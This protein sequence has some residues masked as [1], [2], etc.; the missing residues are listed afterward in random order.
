[1]SWLVLEKVPGAGVGLP[2]TGPS[3]SS[4]GDDTHPVQTQIGKV[5]QLYV[6]FVEVIQ[7]YVEFVE[8][9][10]L[11]VEFVEVIQLY[12]EF[13]EVIQLHVEFDEVIQLHVGFVE[14]IQLHV[15]FVEVIQL[16]VEFVEV[17]QLYVGFVE[18][19]QLHVEF[20]EVIQLHVGYVEVIQLHVEFVEVIQLHVGFVEVIQLYVRFVEVIQLYVEF[21]EVI[22]LYVEYV[23]VIQLYVEVVED[24]RDETSESSTLERSAM[25]ISLDELSPLI[26]AANAVTSGFGSGSTTTAGFSQLVPSGSLSLWLHIPTASC[27]QISSSVISARML[28]PGRVIHS[29]ILSRRMFVPETSGEIIPSVV[30]SRRKFWPGASGGL[31]PSRQLS[32]RI[33]SVGAS[34]TVIPFD[35]LLRMSLIRISHR[36]RITISSG[37]LVSSG[38]RSFITRPSGVPILSGKLSYRM[39][40]VS[41]CGEVASLFF[42]PQILVHEVEIMKRCM[43]VQKT[44][45]YLIKHSVRKSQHLSKS[46][47]P[48]VKYSKETWKC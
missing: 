7:L 27:E 31:I 23:E 24:I 29:T 41:V 12:V 18:V 45:F 37:Y 39:S 48:G 3:C 4:S 21:V 8:V 17:I 43:D 35:V 19:I 15:G 30:L 14:V 20:V 32:R 9:I 2:Y 10:Q 5:I 16:H 22:H 47:Q 42:V 26:C 25:G 1:M 6:E 34:G 33:F 40:N 38:L 13:V 44:D 11:Y 46:I 28:I 36:I